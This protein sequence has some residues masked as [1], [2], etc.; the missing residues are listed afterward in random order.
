MHSYVLVV[1]SPY[2][3]A[4]DGGIH[5]HYGKEDIY[6]WLPKKCDYADE[7]DANEIDLDELENGD[8][9]GELSP[10]I[11]RFL[12]RIDVQLGVQDVCEHLLDCIDGSS[13]LLQELKKEIQAGAHDSLSLFYATSALCNPFGLRIQDGDVQYDITSWLYKK[14][15]EANRNVE[16]SIV[17]EIVQ[18]FHYHY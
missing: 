17:F 12:G 7:I 2:D 4:T 9:F 6:S 8:I 15:V 10:R 16:D 13:F 11:T 14:L 3:E 18:A 1:D 5:P